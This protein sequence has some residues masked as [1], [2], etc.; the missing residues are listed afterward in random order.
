L[1]KLLI[2]IRS[3]RKVTSTAALYD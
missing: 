1:F 2:L 3:R